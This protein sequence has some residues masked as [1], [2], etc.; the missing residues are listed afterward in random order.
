MWSAAARGG[1]AREA[2]KGTRVCTRC[3][4][5]G[6]RSV[7]A[8]PQ[9]AVLRI[10]HGTMLG[11]ILVRRRV[12]SVS[13]FRILSLLRGRKK[14]IC[15]ARRREKGKGGNLPTLK[16]SLA[17]APA[18]A[19]VTAKGAPAPKMAGGTRPTE[20]DVRRPFRGTAGTLALEEELAKSRKNLGYDD[21]YCLDDFEVVVLES[22][23]AVQHAEMLMGA[24]FKDFQ[25]AVAALVHAA[26][27]DAPGDMLWDCVC[28][29]GKDSTPAS[30]ALVAVLQVCASCRLWRP[31]SGHSVMMS[32][33]SCRQA[34][35]SELSGERGSLDHEPALV[36]GAHTDNQA[37]GRAVSPSTVIYIS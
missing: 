31:R 33:I 21:P 3:R 8:L 10:S 7:H 5:G 15:V 11:R 17:A 37:K 22:S 1:A 4:K 32:W 14:N 2:W 34:C 24:P 29:E 28:E 12:D 19:Q 16:K 27:P 26:H 30:N 6:E 18:D 35:Q 23:S 36:A 9:R 25:S 20:E 13:Q